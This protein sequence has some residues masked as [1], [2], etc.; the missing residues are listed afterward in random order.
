LTPALWLALAATIVIETLIAS[1]LLRRFVWLQSI[2]IQLLTWPIA[3]WLA[4]RGTPLLPIELGVFVVEIVLWRL[5]L[6]IS[7]RRAAVVS[8][9]TNG[10]TAAI[11]FAIR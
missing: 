2:A 7:W 3:Q 5:L 11:A 9:A 4:S 10:V 6:P 8:L 1:T